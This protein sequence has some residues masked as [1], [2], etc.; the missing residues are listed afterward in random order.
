MAESSWHLGMYSWS[1]YCVRRWW[2]GFSTQVHSIRCVWA[3]AATSL[4]ARLLQAPLSEVLGSAMLIHL[5]EALGHALPRTRVSAPGL[6]ERRDGQ[7]GGEILSA[8]T[9]RRV[10]KWW[11]GLLPRLVLFRLVTPTLQ[12]KV[13][14]PFYWYGVCC[15]PT[16]CRWKEPAVSRILN[17]NRWLVVPGVL[18]LDTTP[19][20]PPPSLGRPTARGK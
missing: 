3:P 18:Y 14:G 15:F 9:N 17:R 10:E 2:D 4:C 1:C 12:P 7:S 5:L 11:R 8:H 20:S 6:W 13:V 16:V 19:P